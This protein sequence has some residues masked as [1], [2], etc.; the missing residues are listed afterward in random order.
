MKIKQPGEP[1]IDTFNN[2]GTLPQINASCASKCLGTCQ[3]LCV[4]L[5][6]SLC[7]FE[8][9]CNRWNISKN[10][11]YAKRSTYKFI[12]H[13]DANIASTRCNYGR[14]NETGPIFLNNAIGNI[15]SFV[16]ALR[17]R[18]SALRVQKCRIAGHLPGHRYAKSSR[19]FKLAFKNLLR[20]SVWRLINFIGRI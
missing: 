14:F 9:G 19:N 7:T 12:I 3:P 13:R 10:V 20:P 16:P 5:C 17:L 1:K 18:T 11:K 4:N 2:G 8:G 6:A 15:F